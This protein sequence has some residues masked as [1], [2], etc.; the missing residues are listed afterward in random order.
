MSGDWLGTAAES[1]TLLRDVVHVQEVVDDE[2]ADPL[3]ERP[4]AVASPYT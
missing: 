2:P 1:F 3:A 4:K